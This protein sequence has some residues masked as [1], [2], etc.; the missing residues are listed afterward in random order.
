[1]E[2]SS[3]ANPLGRIYST[4][5]GY[6]H[7]WTHSCGHG[8]HFYQDDKTSS[9][10]T[11]VEFPS[12]SNQSS[13]SKNGARKRDLLDSIPWASYCLDTYV[14]ATQSGHNWFFEPETF[15]VRHIGPTGP[16][17]Q[18]MLGVLGLV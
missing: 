16:E 7:G 9:A 15:P 13:H 1:M 14:M 3:Q 2:K 5:I 12:A 18:E 17:I 8:S 4:V 11:F 10:Q 6:L